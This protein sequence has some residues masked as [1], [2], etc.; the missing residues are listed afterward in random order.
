[1]KILLPLLLTVSICT[2]VVTS[3]E[4]WYCI[5][6]CTELLGKDLPGNAGPGQIILP[7]PSH[8]NCQLLVTYR[9]WVCLENVNG[10][11]QLAYRLSIT[12][13]APV[14]IN[15]PGCTGLKSEMYPS[16]YPG[17]VNQDYVLN[18]FSSLMPIVSEY[19]FI[20]DPDSLPSSFRCPAVYRTQEFVQGSCVKLVQ[21]S[22]IS[23]QAGIVLNPFF[24]LAWCTYICCTTTIAHCY[25]TETNTV[26]TVVQSSSGPPRG[27]DA[28]DRIAPPPSGTIL[29]TTCRSTC[30]IN[31]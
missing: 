26:Q 23:T 9:A 5:N 14:D 6:S 11:W 15:D 1:M 4:N 24:S 2:T 7:H 22:H 29:S 17:P 8:P 16:G 12:G 28:L 30:P 3:Q 31:P 20:N 10:S 27:C 13:W 25:N 19:Y 18:M 21:G